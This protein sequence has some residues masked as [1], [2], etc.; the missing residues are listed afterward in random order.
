MT[1]QD[2]ARTGV[3]DAEDPRTIIVVNDDPDF[4]MISTREGFDLFSK[5]WPVTEIR[6]VEDMPAIRII[7]EI[8]TF[9]G[10]GPAPRRAPVAS[11]AP[12]HIE[13]GLTRASR[14][15]MA[16]AAKKDARP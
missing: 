8:P 5:D 2:N 12:A 4:G 9:H 14:R 3:D 16:K 6:H 13:D 10:A 1:I 7:D 15:R 11:T